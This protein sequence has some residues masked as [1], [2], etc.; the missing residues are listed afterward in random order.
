MPFEDS[1]FGRSA[2]ILVA[3][4]SLHTLKGRVR[5]QKIL[6]LANLCGWNCIKDYRYYTYGPYSDAITTELD[7]FKR[8][9]WV[10]EDSSEIEGK[11]WHSYSLTRQGERIADSLAGKIENEKL[12]QKTMNL[13]KQLHASSSD[14]L[15]IMATLVF[16]N[17]SEPSLAGDELVKRVL[18]LKPR[19]SEQQIKDDLKIFNILKN[20]G[21]M[22]KQ[23]N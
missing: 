6:Y 19:F 15:E 3:I 8:N 17:R 22:T 4:R 18:K 10:I 23:V 20:Y 1:H 9:G 7:N 11:Q 5:V 13:A 16:I 21:Y 12:I 2:L 14:D